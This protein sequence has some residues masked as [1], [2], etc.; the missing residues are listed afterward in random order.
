MTVVCL[1]LTT[2]PTRCFNIKRARGIFPH[3]GG[4]LLKKN[5]YRNRIPAWYMHNKH[6]CLVLSVIC[7]YALYVNCIYKD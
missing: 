2:L 5:G 3:G 1:I 6:A 4:I 7:F